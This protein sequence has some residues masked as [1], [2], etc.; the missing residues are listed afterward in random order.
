[1]NK[2]EVGI[3]ILIMCFMVALSGCTSDNNGSNDSGSSN[4]TSGNNTNSSDVDIVIEY[5]GSWACDTSGDFGY[6]SLSGTGDQTNNIGSVQG[7]VVAAARKTD[8]GNGV[9][10]VT[11][12]KDGK[13]LASQSTSAPYGGA[14]AVANE[15]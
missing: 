11:I 13:V 7:T 15:I 6:K 3:L 10:T 9:L 12:M 4:S 2:L 14:T 5:S 8:S 1:M